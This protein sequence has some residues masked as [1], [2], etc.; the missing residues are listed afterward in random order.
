MKN[1]KITFLLLFFAFLCN[2]SGIREAMSGKTKTTDEFLVKKKDPL[3][4]P[5]KYGDL[6]LP[7]SKKEELKEPG[8]EKMLSSSKRK[9]SD[10]KSISNL[11]NMILKEL[12]K[13]N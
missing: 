11:E 9:G 3:V 1:L 7:K 8:L 10:S 5:P 6:P 4:L 2:C 13:N 12:R